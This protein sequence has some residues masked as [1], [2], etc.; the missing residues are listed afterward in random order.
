MGAQNKLRMGVAVVACSDEIWFYVQ[1]SYFTNLPT[2]VNRL[3][4]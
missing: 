3:Q 1:N 4:I 2:Y